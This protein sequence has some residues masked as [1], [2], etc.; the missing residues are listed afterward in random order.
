MDSWKTRT[1]IRIFD[2]KVNAVFNLLIIEA[3]D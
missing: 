1:D 3:E 2:D